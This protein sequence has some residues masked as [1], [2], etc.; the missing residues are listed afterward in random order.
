MDKKNKNPNVPN[1]RFPGF[2]NEW[3][4][5]C[6]ESLITEEKI[7]TSDFEKYPL[8]SFTI[9][10]GII[11]KTERY[12]RGFLIKKDGNLF[13]VVQQNDFVMNPMN[14][15]F[16]A[17]NYSKV[18]K[19]ISVSGYYNIFRI[20]NCKFND[21]WNAYFKTPKILNLYNS[22]ATGSLVEKKRVHFSQ[23]KKIK[24]YMPCELEKQKIDTLIKLLDL[25]IE[26]QSKIINDYISYRNAIVDHFFQSSSSE[27][28]RVK[29]SNILEEYTEL[30]IKDNSI[31]HATLSKDGIFPKTD[32]YDRDF[33]V[34]N[35]DKKYKVT[36]LND[37]CYNPSNLKFG[38]ITRNT[39]GDCI[40][41]PIYVTFK[42]K[43]NYLPE[44]I[45]L[46]VARKHFI[47]KARKYE[48]GT[49]Y[50]RMAVH[51]SD[52]LSMNILIPSL[53]IQKRIANIINTIDIKISNEQKLLNLYIAQ[54][55]YLLK[56]M[57]I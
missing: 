25:R 6:I 17:I 8:H 11:P 27:W 38:V 47:S 40:I 26:T 48:Q 12:E 30:H 2:Y 46:L 18:S 34:K 44:F 10:L 23:F 16:G 36:H 51:P 3:K 32:R 43:N 7:Y 50:E 20:D 56:N 55:G 4:K 41:S 14:L 9:E 54:K 15:R 33:L 49:V 52:L 5:I 31:V 42:I 53:T 13:K 35:D 22:I 39:Y 29:L 19:S 28:K 57:F 21:F 37:I 1:L 45:E 24:M